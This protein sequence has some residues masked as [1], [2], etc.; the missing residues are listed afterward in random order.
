MISVHQRYTR[1]TDKQMTYDGITQPR[2]AWCKKLQLTKN[3]STILWWLTRDREVVGLNALAGLITTL[4]KSLAPTRLC[5][6]KWFRGYEYQ[7]DS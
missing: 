1:Q 7:T 5:G 4:G 3:R 6:F 2:Y